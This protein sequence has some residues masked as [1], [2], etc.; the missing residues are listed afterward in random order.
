[1]LKI[2]TILHVSKRTATQYDFE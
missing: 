1:V 2:S